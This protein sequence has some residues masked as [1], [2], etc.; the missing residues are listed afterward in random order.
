M[1]KWGLEE[2]RLEKP[3]PTYLIFDMDFTLALAD[4]AAKF[5]R[6]VAVQNGF[7]EFYFIDKL[8]K[9]IEEIDPIIKKLERG[10]RHISKG[11]EWIVGSMKRG[12]KPYPG[13][14][15]EQVF[16]EMIPLIASGSLKFRFSNA[17]KPQPITRTTLVRFAEEKI[18][19]MPG[20]KKLMETISKSHLLG[21]RDCFI[22]TAG[23]K[24][25][26]EGIA[27]QLAYTTGA[28]V[29]AMI[30]FDHIFGVDVLTGKGDVIYGLKNY[31][32][33]NKMQNIKKIEEIVRKDIKKKGWQA[34]KHNNPLCHIIYIGDGIT[35]ASA[36]RY[37]STGGKRKGVGM[38]IQLHPQLKLIEK[39]MV[40]FAVIAP[41]MKY[42]WSKLIQ[43]FIKHRGGRQA[44]K[45]IRREIGKGRPVHS[46]LLHRYEI[47]L[48]NYVKGDMPERLRLVAPWQREYLKAP[49]N[50]KIRMRAMRY[51]REIGRTHR[52][53]RTRRR[54]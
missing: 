4:V 48:G 40:E 1:M 49:L 54:K 13:W 6:E 32:G 7:P 34:P 39:G 23:L 18:K 20:M 8:R 31:H 16:K 17:E 44:K 38:S 43:P 3:Y 36:M 15:V 42:L 24:P 21:V 19:L 45:R 33:N 53:P 47:Y 50:K 10:K 22:V 14:A 51:L 28:K 41:N 30:P 35:D 46:S 12:E 2:V 26:A 11:P 5:F 9:Y 29:R 37:V 25:F 27:S 52:T